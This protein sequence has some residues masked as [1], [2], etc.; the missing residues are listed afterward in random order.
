MGTLC[1]IFHIFFSKSKAILKYVN[2]CY[3]LS[4]H[5]MEIVLPFG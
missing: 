3:Y 1:T 2:Y 4:N 5:C